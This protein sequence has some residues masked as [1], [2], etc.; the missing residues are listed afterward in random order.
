MFCR[1]SATSKE[2]KAKKTASVSWKH[3]RTLNLILNCLKEVSSV[4]KMALYKDLVRLNIFKTNGHLILGYTPQT[5]IQPP[6]LS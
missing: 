4:T 1:F 6:S 2:F 5:G 3:E